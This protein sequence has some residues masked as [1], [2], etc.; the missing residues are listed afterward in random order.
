MS[1]FQIILSKSEYWNRIS[2]YFL[3]QGKDQAFINTLQTELF[4]RILILISR[5]LKVKIPQ[6]QLEKVQEI[7]ST[8]DLSSALTF[9]QNALTKNLSRQQFLDI[10][11][12]ATN[13]V[14]ST[15]LDIIIQKHVD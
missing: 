3:A 11:E 8:S 1:D 2:E 6:N 10:Y 15:Y 14:L 12:N 9:A 7:A 13:K 5:E 4:Q